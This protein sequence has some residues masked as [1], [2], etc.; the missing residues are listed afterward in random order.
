M[1]TEN[2]ENIGDLLIDALEEAIEIKEGRA[3]PARVTRVPIS[4]A[5][6]EVRPPPAFSPSRVQKVRRSLLVSQ[7]VFAEMLNVSRKTIAAWEQGT[8]EPRGATLRLL[9][10]AEQDPDVFTSRVRLTV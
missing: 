9:E 2:R 7:A 6:A 5:R 8:R 3:K 4:A 10:L 1:T